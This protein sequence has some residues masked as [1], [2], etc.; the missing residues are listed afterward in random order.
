MGS[1]PKAKARKRHIY[2]FRHCL[3]SSEGTIRNVWSN[4]T[5]VLGSEFTSEPLPDWHVM[6]MACTSRGKKVME[7]EGMFISKEFIQ[8]IERENSALLGR[9]IRIRVVSDNEERDSNSAFSLLRGFADVIERSQMD[10]GLTYDQDLFHPLSSKRIS[11]GLR[12][13]ALLYSSLC[14]RKCGTDAKREMEHRMELLPRPKGGFPFILRLLEKVTGSSKWISEADSNV[15]SVSEDGE[16]VGIVQLIKA[17]SQIVFYSRASNVS[18]TPFLAKATAK[19]MYRLAEWGYYFQ[20]LTQMETNDVAIKA[21]TL[22]HSVLKAL[23][24]D[25]DAPDV[26]IFVGHDT[27]ITR[28]ASVFG[29]RWDLAEPYFT[30]PSLSGHY[31]PVPPGSALH[32][33]HNLESGEVEMSFRYPILVSAKGH[34]YWRAGGELATIGPNLTGSTE[35]RFS[36]TESATAFGGVQKGDGLQLLEDRLMAT[37]AN[38][39][40]AMDCFNRASQLSSWPERESHA[41]SSPFLHSFG[42]AAPIFMVLIVLLIM[43]RVHQ[44]AMFGANQV[45][46]SSGDTITIIV[47]EEETQFI[48]DQE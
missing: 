22:A 1:D 35:G 38:H 34:L 15:M 16:V 46:K 32:F 45:E 39:E 18:E 37:L 20:A 42:F 23:E 7:G 30:S 40:G 26:T 48:M 4:G 17:F 12:S 28:M 24:D 31:A 27:D 47:E 43:K 14:E 29:L 33:V 8:Q 6:P 11:Y 10:V 5:A 44:S 3:R 21:S 25:T 19:D 2:L 13:K 9:R 41:S 36:Q